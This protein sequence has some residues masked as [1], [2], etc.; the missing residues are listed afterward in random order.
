MTNKRPLSIATF[1]F[2]L[3]CIWSA[4]DPKVV[5]RVDTQVW[6]KLEMLSGLFRRLRSPLQL[7]SCL[8][9]CLETTRETSCFKK[10]LGRLHNFCCIFR[11]LPVLRQI[12]C[13][14]VNNIARYLAAWSSLW[15]VPS[16]IIVIQL[17]HREQLLRSFRIPLR[18]YLLQ[19]KLDRS[20]PRFA[21]ILSNIAPNIPDYLDFEGLSLS[22]PARSHNISICPSSP[23]L[24]KEPPP[25]LIPLWVCVT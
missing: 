16:S 14:Y 1:L 2:Q 11:H 15:F 21:E 17:I 9:I 13:I 10:S 22:L 18:R 5:Y 3:S 8:Y 23:I 19:V 24:V 20:E 6:S 25:S 7:L 4:V 12:E